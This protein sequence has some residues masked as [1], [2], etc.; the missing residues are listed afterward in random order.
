MFKKIKY[1]LEDVNDYIDDVC[2]EIP[3]FFSNDV[4]LMTWL[5]II[6]Y[7]I[8]GFF[9]AILSMTA[10]MVFRNYKL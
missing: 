6:V 9:P 7:T 2:R 10:F 8:L 1:F 5:G 3:A 4:L